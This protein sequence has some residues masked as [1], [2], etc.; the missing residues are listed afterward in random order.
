[1]QLLLIISNYIISQDYNRP[2]DPLIE[3]CNKQRCGRRYLELSDLIHND[4][5][6]VIFELYLVKVVM[7]LLNFMSYVDDE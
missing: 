2:K 1:M 4:R 3:G 7:Y 6:F 5:N